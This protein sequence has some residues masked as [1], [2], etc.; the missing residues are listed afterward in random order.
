MPKI[1]WM[2]PYYDAYQRTYGMAP[3]KI[4]CSRIGR[5]IRPLD[6][7]HGVDAV[8]PAYLRYC[9][10]TPIRFYSA[11]RFAETYPAWTQP[12]AGQPRDPNEPRPGEDIDAYIRR[13]GTS[14]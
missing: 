14:R 3:S 8:A 12:D 1:T 13:Q 2:T 4:A 11:E 7:E 6:A 10:A 5:V 9:Q